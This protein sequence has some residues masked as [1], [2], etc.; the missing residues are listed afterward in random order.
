MGMQGKEILVK[1]IENIV[2]V[3]FIKIRIKTN[4]WWGR[5]LCYLADRF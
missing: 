5:D 3:C 2:L 4:W 1:G